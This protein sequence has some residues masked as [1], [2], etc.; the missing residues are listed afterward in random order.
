MTTAAAI[1]ALARDARQALR[2]LRR[3]PLFTLVAL[4]T[5]AIGIGATTAVFSVVDGV[6]LKP[7][8]YPKPEE[9]VALR[10]D[11][12]GLAGLAGGV[13]SMGATPSMLIAYRELNRTFASLGLYFQTGT[14]VIAGSEPE[15]VSLAYV[16]GVLLG[17][18]GP[19]PLPARW[20]TVDD[21]AP[22]RPPVVVLSYNYWQRRFGGDPSVVGKT[23]N[24]NA[25]P[26]EIVGVMPKDFRIAAF[27]PTLIGSLTIDRSN[28]SA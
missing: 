3:S 13:G 27:D 10:H 18:L 9:L 17:S 20:I 22:G 25:V 8:G 19:P 7:L 6:L 11:T 2:G 26:A 14:N 15:Q 21:E 1:D 4:L 24:W 23:L 16:N 28:P 12:P 5:L